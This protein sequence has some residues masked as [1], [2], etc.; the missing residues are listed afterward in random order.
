MSLDNSIGMDPTGNMLFPPVVKLRLKTVSRTIAI[1]HT[2]KLYHC[3]TELVRVGTRQL[4]VKQLE[5]THTRG[6][7]YAFV[8]RDIPQYP[9]LFQNHKKG[10]PFHEFIRRY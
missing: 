2:H 9:S 5:N 6:C 7:G 4:L 1:L 3:F 8:A 10:G